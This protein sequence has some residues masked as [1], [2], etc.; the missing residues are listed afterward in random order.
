MKANQTLAQWVATH[1]GI[2]PDSARDGEIG[3]IRALNGVLRGRRRVVSPTG[4]AF[5]RMASLAREAGFPVHDEDEFLEALESDAGALASKQDTRG[6]CF[7]DYQL[8]ES[9]Q[10][11]EYECF[12][13][14]DHD[15]THGACTVCGRP[16]ENGLCPDC[17]RWAGDAMVELLTRKEQERQCLRFF[18]TMRG[19]T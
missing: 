2:A 18:E 12:D 1:G 17:A 19:R 16:D 7:T 6:R 8:T 10:D 3:R 14:E 15:H 4:Q 5:D 13:R 9:D 11:F